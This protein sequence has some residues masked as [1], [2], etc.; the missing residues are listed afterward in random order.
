MTEALERAGATV[1]AVDALPDMLVRAQE[2]APRSTFV[3]GDL[4]EIDLPAAFDRVVLSFVLHNFDTPGRVAVLA[5]AR[6]HLLDGG[7]VGILDW[8]LP[9]GALRQRIWRGF[10]RRIEPSPTVGEILGGALVRDLATAG[11]RIDAS[12]TVV[13]GRAQILI[14]V[15]A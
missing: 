8:A 4:G 14:A 6:R 5:L 3:Q 1:T 15:P 12:H 2:R 10:L 9:P 11:L 7:S 13:G